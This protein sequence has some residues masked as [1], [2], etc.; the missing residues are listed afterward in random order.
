MK[1]QRSSAAR[2]HHSLSAL[3]E[4]VVADEQVTTLSSAVEEENSHTMLMRR[5][6]VTPMRVIYHYPES[7]SS[8]R[9]VRE[10]KRPD[11]FLRL[12]FRDEDLG[13]LNKSS[14]GSKMSNVY[15]RIASLLKNGVNLCG[16][17]YAFLAMSSSQLREH[18]EFG[19]IMGD[20]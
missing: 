12:R 11:L 13:K 4:R 7:C 15:E 10:F 5:A 2:Y 1:L 9:V 18:G 17:Q 19:F 16:T 14:C 8:N 20:F 6:T 3:L